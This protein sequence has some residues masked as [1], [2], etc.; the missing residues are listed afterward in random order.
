MLVK[1]TL[2]VIEVGREDVVVLLHLGHALLYGLYL[3]FENSLPNGYLSLGYARQVSGAHSA[4]KADNGDV[5]VEGQ[6]Q[7][8]P[9]IKEIWV[10]LDCFPWIVPICWR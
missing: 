3:G 1:L 9:Q 4:G 6:R 8:H 7:I 5:N 10:D 2:S